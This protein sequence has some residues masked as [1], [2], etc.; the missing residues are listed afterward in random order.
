[1][2]L[3]TFVMYVF[4]SIGIIVCVVVTSI[5]LVWVTCFVVRLL[6]KT[7]GTKV[8]SYTEI[9]VEDIKEK[10]K[11]KRELK[12]QERQAQKEHK[13]ELLKVR[14]E[15]K[16]RLNDMKKKKL[17]EK[18]RAKEA[19]KSLKLFGS[20]EEPESV[21]DGTKGDEQ[22]VAQEPEMVE[23]NHRKKSSDVLEIDEGNVMEKETES[24]PSE[25]QTHDEDADY[26]DY[27]SEFKK[28]EELE[29]DAKVEESEELPDDKK[30]ANEEVYHEPKSR[31]EKA[32]YHDEREKEIAEK[33]K[34]INEEKLDDVQELII[35][36]DE[37]DGEDFDE[38]FNSLTD[39]EVDESKTESENTIKQHSD[40]DFDF[41]K[42]MQ[43]E[44][45]KESTEDDDE[46]ETEPE[47]EEKTKKSNRKSKK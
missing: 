6:V 25:P 45:E 46:V 20:Y 44:F 29:K 11:V 8:G 13:E 15:S 35:L 3:K 38:K 22:T 4:M 26:F 17:E 27:T 1:M 21:F 43:E 36:D 39:I 30:E 24:T 7:F 42:Y 40:D 28:P 31:N 2:D 5:A 16:K 19:Q 23:E 33:L 32:D 47:M 12:E 18:L 10:S 14:L 41:N 37:D 9:V 34:Q